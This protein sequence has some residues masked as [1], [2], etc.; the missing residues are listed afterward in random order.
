M[1]YEDFDDVCADLPRYIDTYNTRR[2][3]SAL[4]ISARS[5]SRSNTRSPCQSRLPKLSTPRGALQEMC[6]FQLPLTAGAE[7]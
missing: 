5:S 6:S 2:L 3:H 7:S 1:D 4:G